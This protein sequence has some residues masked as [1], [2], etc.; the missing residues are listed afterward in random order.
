MSNPPFILELNEFIKYHI[1]SFC[2][3]SQNVVA[4]FSLGPYVLLFKHCIT[5]M[6][7]K[8]NKEKRKKE[9]ERKIVIFVIYIY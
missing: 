5:F 4:A 1:S 9:K 6:K 3:L 2:L 8:K 7:R